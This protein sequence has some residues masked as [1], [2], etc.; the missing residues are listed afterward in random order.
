MEY[1]GAGFITVLLGDIMTMPGLP[2]KPAAE[3]IDVEPSK[4]FSLRT[5]KNI[6][7]SINI[8]KSSTY[9]PVSGKIDMLPIQMYYFDRVNRNNFVQYYVVKSKTTININKFQEKK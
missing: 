4:I 5:P 2:K 6:A 8:T 1:D 9:K 3:N 7:K